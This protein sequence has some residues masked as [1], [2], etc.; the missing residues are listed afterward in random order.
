MKQRQADSQKQTDRDSADVSESEENTEQ[1]AILPNGHD[2]IS[3]K[4]TVCAQAV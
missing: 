1:V 3:D 4:D 2:R